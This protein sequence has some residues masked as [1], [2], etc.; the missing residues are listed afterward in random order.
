MNL[1][2][3]LGLQKGF[4]SPNHEGLLSVFFTG[5][6]IRK[7]GR[8]FFKEFGLTE[9][10]FNILSLIHYQAEP[11]R[12]LNQN[13]LSRMMLVNRSNMTGL[14]D[15]MEKAGLVRRVEIPRDRRFNEIRVTPKGSRLYKQVED[16]YME[17]VDQVMGVLTENERK[18]LVGMLGRLRDSLKGRKA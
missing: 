9:I 5:E 2:D 14:I 4:E 17:S 6:L 12:G 11:G 15:R 8:D 3:E 18:S 13:E 7:Q 1:K 10:Q 16:G